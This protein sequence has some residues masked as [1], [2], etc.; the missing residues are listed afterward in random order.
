[1]SV[2]LRELQLNDFRNHTQFHVTDAQQLILI[3]GDN[4]TGKTNIIEAIQLV[5]MMDS[6]RNPHWSNLI[7]QGKEK[8]CVMAGF[9]QNER[10]LDIQME[11]GDGNK[12]YLLNGKKK[13]KNDLIG[14]NPAV[15]FIPDDLGL[16]K[17]SAE[18]RRR[19]I[20]DIG[21]QLSSTYKQVLQDYQKTVKQRNAILKE[22]YDAGVITP[23]LES[24]NEN[25]ITL[26]AL[27][28]THRVRLF[29][30]YQEKIGDYYQRI[31]DK[32]SI[33]SFYLPSFLKED[34]EM[35]LLELV[36]MSKDEVERRLYAHLLELR[37]REY[38]SARTLIGPHRDEVIFL[39]DGQDSRRFASQG[40][41]RSI[42]LAL[43]LGQLALIREISG[44]QPIL[45]LDDVMS[46]LD[47][48]RRDML[49]KTLDGQI[50]TII[51]TTDLSCFTPEIIKGA[52]IITLGP[53][54]L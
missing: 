46:E 1:M 6:F 49:I 7:Y 40:Q 9:C 18:T 4:A 38:L 54:K 22:H 10:L 44:N 25:L 30:R 33:E 47:E 41:Q 26:G 15:V 5:S 24:W 3:V 51:T 52:Q 20:D 28:F 27:L 11:V 48:N 13:R 39:L 32:E 21:Q 34:E 45:L 37:E 8:A 23:L 53:E 35:S 43:K 31:T 16:I 36:D 2:V 19:L 50:Q 12:T 17:N 29:K 42:A 14:L